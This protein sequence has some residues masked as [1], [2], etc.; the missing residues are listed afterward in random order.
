[1]SHDMPPCRVY[2]RGILWRCAYMECQTS[3][4]LLSSS[5]KLAGMPLRMRQQCIVRTSDGASAD[6]ADGMWGLASVCTLASR[7][8]GP[9]AARR[10]CIRASPFS[11]THIAQ[12][13]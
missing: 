4:S 7:S 9:L 13:A 6:R 3:D 2:L 1:M 12:A 10:A 5:L 11:I 8:T